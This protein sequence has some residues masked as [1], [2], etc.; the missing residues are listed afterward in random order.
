MVYAQLLGLFVAFV[1]VPAWLLFSLWQNPGPGRYDW[2]VRTLHGGIA[3]LTLWLIGRWDWLSYSLRYLIPA[4]FLVVGILTYRRVAERPFVSGEGPARWFKN[5]QALIESLIFLVALAFVFRGRAVGKPAVDLHFPLRDGRYYV[6]HG[7]KNMTVNMHSRVEPQQYAL[8]I[9][10]LT[11]MGNKARGLLPEE[12]ERYKIFGDT[13]VSPCRGQV[14]ETEGEMPDLTPP[15]RNPDKPAGNHVVL[16]CKDVK[17]LLAHLKQGS[18]QV[19][20]G[21]QVE[22]GQPLGMVG[23]SGNTSEPH[24]HIHAVARGS[25]DVMA[26]DPVPLQFQGRYL[27]RNDII[28]R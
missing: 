6:A 24:L 4:A 15:D 21:E 23:N 2:M 14:L 10:E 12:L 20:E 11:G 8:D 3:L 22:V 27:V 25:G 5:K 16:A 18:L 17:I 13:V 9:V 1:L 26:G 19:E 28:N 7:G